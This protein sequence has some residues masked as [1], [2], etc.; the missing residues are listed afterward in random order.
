MNKTK[1]PNGP[2]VD[3]DVKVNIMISTQRLAIDIMAI[4]FGNI[5]VSV[6]RRIRFLEPRWNTFRLEVTANAALN[7]Y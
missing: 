3:G 2:V 4:T 6:T 5:T 1:R 7:N